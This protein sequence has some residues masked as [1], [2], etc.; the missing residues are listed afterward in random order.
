MNFTKEHL[1]TYHRDGYVVVRNFFS[2]EEADLL[3]RV[4]VD[5][6]L[7]RQKSYDRTD[8]SGLKTKLALWYS[9]DDSLYSKFA[10]AA[11]TV[12]AVEQLL[13]GS[14]AHY[15]SKLMQKEPRTGRS[16]GVA[17]GLW[18]LVQKQRLSLSGHAQRPYRPDARYARERLSADDPGL[19]QNGPRGTWLYGRAG[20]GRYGK[21]QRSR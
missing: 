17:S 14:V 19:A 13:G 20:R 10:S 8:A 18:V 4:A 1:E 5:D 12:Q 21:S 11:R 7:L 3:H 15:H 9:L 6:S 2:K 16:L